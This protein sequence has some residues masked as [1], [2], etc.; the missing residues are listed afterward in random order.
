MRRH[1]PLPVWDKEDIHEKLDL[2]CYG[3]G[4][5]DWKREWLDRVVIRYRHHLLHILK[6]IEIWALI[7]WYKF[8][9]CL[10]GVGG[11]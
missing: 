1:H 6:I 3:V 4:F 11:G 7:A 8:Q 5:G 2:F 10:V 9:L